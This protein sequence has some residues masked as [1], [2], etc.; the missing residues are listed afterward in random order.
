M[1]IFD[2]EF[3][4]S[5]LNELSDNSTSKIC[6]GA[7]AVGAVDAATASMNAS[8]ADQVAMMEASSQIQS[9][10]SAAKAKADIESAVS[11]NTQETVG[12]LK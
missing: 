11:R 5:L 12:K 8:A 7:G 2:L 10:L 1:K 3:K 4:E 9:E 6:G